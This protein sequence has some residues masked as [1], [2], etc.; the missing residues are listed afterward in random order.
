MVALLVFLAFAMHSYAG[1]RWG[2][3]KHAPRRAPALRAAIRPDFTVEVS[4]RDYPDSL[5]LER[6]LSGDDLFA[7]TVCFPPHHTSFADTTLIPNV[8]AVYRLRPATA[9][10]LAEYG[11]ET[12]VT[13]AL[14]ALPPP[15]LLRVAVD[16][17]RITLETLNVL[18]DNIA[19]ERRID[20]LFT[21]IGHL[22]NRSRS[23]CEGGVGTGNQHYR[24]RYQG[25]R[26]MGLP[27]REDSIL[28]VLPPP[29][30]IAIAYTNDHTAIV[31][32]QPGLPFLCAYDIEKRSPKGVQI[33]D[34]EAGA[35]R[36]TEAQLGYDQ[37]TYYRVRAVSGRDSSDYSA[38]VS[39]HYVL[40][41]V[42]QFR[43]DPVH[44]PV[45][46][47][48]WGDPDS[49]MS[50]YVVERSS[51]S[52]LFAALATL[53]GHTFAYADSANARGKTY[54][55]RVISIAS[56]GRSA[57]S[58]V[59]AESIPLLEEGMV[60]VP[61]SSGRPG[62]YCDVLEMSA[63][64]YADFC[65][66]TGRELPGDPA[67]PGHPDYWTSD[68]KLPAVNV[69]WNDAV[70]FCNWRSTSVGLQPAYDALGRLNPAASGYRL[71]DR[72][73]FVR[74]LNSVA[75]TSANLLDTMRSFGEPV[76][77]VMMDAH[78]VA[79]Y[80]LIGNVWEWS[81]ESVAD[82]GHV[83]LGG[84]YCTPRRMSGDIP[85]FCYRAD[86]ISPT[87]GFRCILPAPHL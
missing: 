62:F 59:V 71:P 2:T 74:V 32:W 45:V 68:N 80:N 78:H 16:S 42:T 4:W 34:A 29:S 35:T 57:S 72:A 40:R 53:G 60:H 54:F 3:R 51:D 36:W 30:G 6:C 22:T 11:E 70:N 67:F 81:N 10:Y 15:Q 13:V 41:P 76:V 1:E 85:E 17:V 38:P 12:S 52:L 31:S 44:D 14:P 33:F 49:L 83:I 18:A 9:R 50:V 75:D 25:A 69:S 87:I 79:V 55:Y 77:P 82:G 65:R 48:T 28:M 23:F 26:F 86:Y 47:L 56:S 20:G 37:T 84:A 19:V 64:R 46:H 8:R 21:L 66:E 58:D 61:D 43:A 27:S 24:L 63:A 73:Q 5:C 7:V 39:A